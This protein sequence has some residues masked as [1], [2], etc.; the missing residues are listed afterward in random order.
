MWNALKTLLKAKTTADYRATVIAL[1]ALDHEALHWRLFS[2]DE[3]RV[4][5][6]ALADLARFVHVEFGVA[7]GVTKVV[8]VPKRVRVHARIH[9]QLRWVYWIKYVTTTRLVPNPVI[10]GIVK[11][12]TAFR[13]SMP[14]PYN[15]GACW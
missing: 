1:L 4:N 6:C 3:G 7:Q 2:H 8:R 15:T 9:G 10:T 13:E 11:A 14:F 5:A 12:A